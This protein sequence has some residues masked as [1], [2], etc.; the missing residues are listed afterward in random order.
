MRRTETEGLQIVLFVAP[1]VTASVGV[2]MYQT[3]KQRGWSQIT[4]ADASDRTAVDVV[5]R[6]GAD[7]RH[8]AVEC[9]TVSLREKTPLTDGFTDVDQTVIREQGAE[10]V[11]NMVADLVEVKYVEVINIG[12]EYL[13]KNGK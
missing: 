8:V 13:S 2:E 9:R 11:R 5:C 6:V 4:T 10:R 12:V 3:L 1:E 7:E